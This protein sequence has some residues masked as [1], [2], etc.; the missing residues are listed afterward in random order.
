M[1]HTLPTFALFAIALAAAAAG[2]GPK[3]ASGAIARDRFV[4]ANVDLR[5]VAD[6]VAGADS[7]RKAALR[8][9]RVTE[10]QLRHFVD[11]HARAPEYLSSVWR[12]V[13]DSLQRRF[14]RSFPSVQERVR[15]A[16]GGTI[17]GV[18]PGGIPGVE[19]NPI[20]PGVAK[21]PVI[22]RGIHR[23]PPP[24]N[25][26]PPPTTEPPRPMVREAPPVRRPP[27]GLPPDARG[28]TTVPV[29]PPVVQ[30]R[31]TLD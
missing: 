8:K 12:E 22:E 26:P 15:Q 13:S 16:G 28:P 21:P 2:C 6:T 18:E 24:P 1:R 7:L 27:V 14:E 20:P 11:I 31:D 9:H 4:R 3:Q 23:A 30:P 29:R 5:A 25:Q 10:A 17:P 19:P